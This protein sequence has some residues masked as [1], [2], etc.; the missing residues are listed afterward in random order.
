MTD[1]AV[2]E[3]TRKDLPDLDEMVNAYLGN[4]SGVIGGV[5][6][7]LDAV[8]AHLNANGGLP[9]ED[10]LWRRAHSIVERERDQAR[11]QWKKWE[12]KAD[13][14]KQEHD[15]LVVHG[16]VRGDTYAAMARERDEWKARAE[17][18]EARTTPAVTREDVEKAIRDNEHRV[19]DDGFMHHE[20]DITEAADA[21]CALFG[22]EAESAD[23]LLDKA[24]EF[25]AL[26][27]WELTDREA[28]LLHT[29]A[30]HV[31]GQEAD[32]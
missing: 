4:E 27:D 10:A 17:A 12:H 24:Q 30:A 21:V 11:E 5:I 7:V 23:P 2:N 6:T 18:A 19:N 13:E 26:A 31:L 15:L 20:V 1:H 32:R 14:W 9:A 22:V 28:E 29:V 16:S 25:A 8:V 3:W